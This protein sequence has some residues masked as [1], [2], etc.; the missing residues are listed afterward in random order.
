[1]GLFVLA[2]L[3]LLKHSGSVFSY[4]HFAFASILALAIAHPYFLICSGRR[5]SCGS[6]L[7]LCVM[8][9]L[10]VSNSLFQ[11]ALACRLLCGVYLWTIVVISLWTVSGSLILSLK[12]R[13][14]VLIFFQSTLSYR[15][16]CS[17]ALRHV[18]LVWI[19]RAL[20]WAAAIS[21]VVVLHL[22][23]L[24]M[25]TMSMVV[26]L[27]SSHPVGIVTILEILTLRSRLCIHL[28]SFHPS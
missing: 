27:L 2:F 1:M 21:I 25:I 20:Y 10:R 9:H 23:Y 5:G 15:S 17:W 22:V 24:S 13:K 4:R 3:T 19:F 16:G 18:I 14:G 7:Y 8:C 6:Y 11:N 12:R 28:F 26:P